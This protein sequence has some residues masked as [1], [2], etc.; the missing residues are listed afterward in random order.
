M[1]ILPMAKFWENTAPSISP[2]PTL[3]YGEMVFD[4]ALIPKE[5]TSNI[6]VAR[7]L[8][9][10]IKKEDFIQAAQYQFWVCK[11]GIF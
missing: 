10:K 9:F 2:I 7:I 5:M 8:F 1:F 4:C 11:D 6:K 3:E